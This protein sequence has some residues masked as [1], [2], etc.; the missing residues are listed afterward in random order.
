M[1][2]QAL[3]KEPETHLLNL[4]LNARIKE[5]VQ[6]QVPEEDKNIREMA[7]VSCGTERLLLCL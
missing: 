5:Q 6:A 2:T 3:Q 4:E 7:L 1:G